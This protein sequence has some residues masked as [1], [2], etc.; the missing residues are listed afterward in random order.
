MNF[1][2]TGNVNF[3]YELFG[4]G[5]SVL[6]FI[7]GYTCDIDFWRPVANA[8]KNTHR[9]L[10]FDNQGIGLTRDNGGVLIV[11]ELAQNI[12][13]MLFKLG[14]EKADFFGFAFGSSIALQ[15]AYSFPNLVSQL[16]LLSP[17]VS[18]REAA[19]KNINVLIELRQN[20]KLDLYF[21]KLLEVAFGQGFKQA[22]NFAD[23]K[24]M[25]SEGLSN[26]TLLDQIR[27]AD[28]L[29]EF[30]A[31]KWI[32]EV[33]VPATVIAPTEDQFST[34]DDARVVAKAIHA[35]FYQL[36]CGHA[37][38]LEAEKELITVC[39]KAIN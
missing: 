21:K 22:V 7:A 4:E 30:D 26:Q 17:V 31:T 15:L 20:N 34:L 36:S 28:A 11:E 14:I 18:W 8:L 35:D 25:I 5:D 23:F 1:L 24:M 16:V 10:I 37:V 38:L 33:S 9:V 27:Q 13:E 39:K 3:H 6:V 32:A 19:I 2:D 12:Q 29:K